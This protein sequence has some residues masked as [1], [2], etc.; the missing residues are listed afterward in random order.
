MPS[1]CLPVSRLVAHWRMEAFMTRETAEVFAK[2]SALWTEQELRCMPVRDPQAPRHFP[3]VSDRQAVRG[4]RN[5]NV[6]ASSIQDETWLAVPGST[7]DRKYDKR[8]GS[9]A[10]PLIHV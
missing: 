5:G 1:T 8:T 9:N 6:P 10:R 7:D 2:E 4:D 3:L